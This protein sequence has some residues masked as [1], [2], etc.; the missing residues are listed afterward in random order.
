MSS[1]PQ[2]IIIGA[3]ISGLYTAFQFA[4]SKESPSFLILEQKP[5]IGGRIKSITIESSD[6]Q[7]SITYDAGALRIS[8]NHTKTLDLLNRLELTDSLQSQ[9]KSLLYY[10]QSKFSKTTPEL[11]HLNTKI[12]LRLNWGPQ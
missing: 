1:S 9:D 5:Y 12:E 7:D 8:S 11:K 4:N 3:G 10:L 6:N 2:V